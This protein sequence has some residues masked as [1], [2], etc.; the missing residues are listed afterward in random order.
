MSMNS[1]NLKGVTMTCVSQWQPQLSNWASGLLN[2][3][4]VI[5]GTGNLAHYQG[6]VKS[7]VLEPRF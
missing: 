6:L 5:L 4:G 7:W 3:K 1:H 2:K